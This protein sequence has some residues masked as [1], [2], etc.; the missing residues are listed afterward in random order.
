[1]VEY[2]LNLSLDLPTVNDLLTNEAYVGNLHNVF[3]N[4]AYA[5]KLSSKA[6][7][8]LAKD[9]DIEGFVAYYLNIGERYIYV[10]LLAVN[11]KY[12]HQ[13]IAQNMVELLEEKYSG[14]Y[15]CINLEVYKS[16]ANA[17]RF[18]YAQGFN[19][20][21]EKSNSLLLSKIIQK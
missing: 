13:G 1:M 12:R 8:L 19:I 5:E 18:Y 20:K 17:L 11:N 15:D 14:S 10:T 4:S 6:K 7:F 2:I 16:N 3:S 9:S 21:E